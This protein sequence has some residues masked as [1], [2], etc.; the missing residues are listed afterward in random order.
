MARPTITKPVYVIVANHRSNPLG[1]AASVPEAKAFVKEAAQPLIQKFG[2][3]RW[4]GSTFN[5]PKGSYM[6][7]IRKTRRIGKIAA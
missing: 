6:F 1:V 4:S 5:G 3:G 7:S 2:S